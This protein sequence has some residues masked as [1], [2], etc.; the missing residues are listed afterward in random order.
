MREVV[1]R[2]HNGQP[3]LLLVDEVSLLIAPIVDSRLT[4]PAV[5]D[6]EGNDAAPYRL[7]LEVVERREE[8]VIWLR[9]RVDATR[10]RASASQRGNS[11][12]A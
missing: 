11:P 8:D 9:Y 10:P 7:V 4:M 3:Q 5:F 6:L 1:G 12:A 2:A